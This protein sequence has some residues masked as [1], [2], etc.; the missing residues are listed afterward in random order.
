MT[1]KYIEREIMKGIKFMRM[2]QAVV[3][4]WAEKEI[5]DMLLHIVRI[6]LFA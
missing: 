2:S 1:E 3:Y 4:S 5:P 6:F